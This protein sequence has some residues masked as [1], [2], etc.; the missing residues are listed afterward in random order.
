MSSV[1]SLSFAGTIFFG[2]LDENKNLEAGTG[3]RKAGEV[4]PFSMT[5]TTTNKKMSSAMKETAGQT[6]HSK[7]ELDEVTGSATFHEWFAAVFA[8]AMAGEESAMT[9]SGG[10]VSSESVTL[11]LDQWVR[12]ANAGVS[13][14]TIASATEDTDYKVNTDLGM[15]ML[16]STANI[17]AGATNVA[18]T[19]AAESGYQVKIGTQAQIRVA[20]L[21]DGKN[22]ETGETITAE[23]YS[24]VLSPN[25]ETNLISEPDSDFDSMA[26]DLVFE[27][28][29]TKDCP[30]VIN[31]IPLQ[32]YPG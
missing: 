26:F 2:L 15:I 32:Y 22:L 18:Y 4:Y 6:K 21:L 12:L 27:T 1:G 20:I 3:Y 24:V 28:P 29:S 10:T 13:A 16:I 31:G 25:T 8:W 17:P 14:V 7:T 19:F 23:F 9:G 5:I 30:G 11:I